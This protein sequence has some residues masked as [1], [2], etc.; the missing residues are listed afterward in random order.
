MTSG[1][2]LGFT[3]Q[4]SSFVE[5]FVG[6]ADSY[7]KDGANSR[8]C[9]PRKGLSVMECLRD[10]VICRFGPMGRAVGLKIGPNEPI[11]MPLEPIQVT[12]EPVFVPNGPILSRKRGA[13]GAQ[14]ARAR[15]LGCPRMQAPDSP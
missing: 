10:A 15:C 3:F 14:E 9:S 1:W 7:G 5:P 8:K 12:F 13:S 2:S 4:S 6:L 11:E